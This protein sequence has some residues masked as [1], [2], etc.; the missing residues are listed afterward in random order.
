MPGRCSAN[1]VTVPACGPRQPVLRQPPG[2]RLGEHQ[3]RPVCGRGEAVGEVQSLGHRADRAVGVAAE[4]PAVTACLEDRALEVRV[5]ELGRR[6]G[7][8]DGAVGQFHDVRAELQA[9]AVHRFHEH[10]GRPGARYPSPAGRPG[11]C[12]SAVAR[13]GPPSGPAGGRRCDRP[14][15][16]H[17]PGRSGRCCRRSVRSTGRR[18]RRRRCPRVPR[19]VRRRSSVRQGRT[20]AA[21]RT[22]AAASA[23]DRSGLVVQW[24]S[25][26]HRRASAADPRPG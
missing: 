25:A 9:P 11:W 6:L 7:E 17:R 13:R 12:R 15:G 8:V 1:R 3:G 2:L 18:R 5:G 23:P 10:L 24:P 26:R 22:A 19:Q 14:P 20:P 4:Q 21:A 16:S